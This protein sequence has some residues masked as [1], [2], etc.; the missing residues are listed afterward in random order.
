MR[1]DRFT[2]TRTLRAPPARVFAAWAD[3]HAKR[4]WFADNDGPGWETLDHAMDFR[5]DGRDRG[6]WR[7]T[8]DDNP[9]AGEHALSAIYLDIVASTRIVTAYTMAKDG[10]THSASLATVTFAPD[11]TGT[12]LTYTEQIALYDDADTTRSR[13]D[14]N[15]H[16]LDSLAQYLG[17][18]A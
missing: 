8:D 18:P 13:I 4:A 6:L 7:L 15:E 11:G 12:A 14:G 9:V 2:L 1:H 10:R 5:I 3:R 16:L 17:E